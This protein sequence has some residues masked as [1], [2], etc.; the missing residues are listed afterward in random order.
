MKWIDAF[1]WLRLC[2]TER[3]AYYYFWREVGARMGIREIP[4]SFDA[5]LQWATNFERTRFRYAESNRKIGTVTGDLFATWGPRLATPVHYGI[6]ALLDDE[7]I[8]AFGFPRPLPGS[9]TLVR[10]VLSRLEDCWCAGWH[11]V[12]SWA[13]SPTFRIALTRKDMTSVGWG[14]R[15]W[16]RRSQIATGRPSHP[17]IELIFEVHPLIFPRCCFCR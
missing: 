13:F 4:G 2:D 8:E 7:M 9:R 17:S 15:G 12:A 6:Y 16:W 1:G 3:H 11:R 14:P 5:F 10:G